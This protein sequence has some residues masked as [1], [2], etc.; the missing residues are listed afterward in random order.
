MT[1]RLFRD[2]ISWSETKSGKSSTMVAQMFVFVCMF[3][4]LLGVY[5][6]MCAYAV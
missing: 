3:V 4:P 2:L 6:F 1:I 5:T